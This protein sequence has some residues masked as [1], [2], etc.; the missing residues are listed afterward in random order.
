LKSSSTPKGPIGSGA[1]GVGTA[2]G[3]WIWAAIT[4]ARAELELSGFGRNP[5]AKSG[6]S[7][8]SSFSGLGAE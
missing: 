5:L 8:G 1:S 2:I 6:F 7:A 3:A 4:R